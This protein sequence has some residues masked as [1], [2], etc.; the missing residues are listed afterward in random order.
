[1]KITVNDLQKINME[2]QTVTEEIMQNVA[3]VLATP[4]YSVPLDRGLGLNMT[5][6]TSRFPPQRCWQSGT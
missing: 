3:V 1:M 6:L 4:K 2:P 5:F